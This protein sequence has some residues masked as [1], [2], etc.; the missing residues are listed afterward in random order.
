[1]D[2]VHA[3]VEEARSKSSMHAC[4]DEVMDKITSVT[5]RM[6]ISP[7]SSSRV[8]IQRALWELLAKFILRAVSDEL[9]SSRIRRE[10]LVTLH[11][12]IVHLPAV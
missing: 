11:L 6:R 3:W 9:R 10:K 7:T 4:V 2:G 12:P 1:M 5:A 8:N